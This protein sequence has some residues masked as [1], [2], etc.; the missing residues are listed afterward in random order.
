MTDL[1]AMS[2]PDRQAVPFIDLRSVP[3]SEGAKAFVQTLLEEIIL[4]TWPA[5]MQQRPSTILK[6]RQVLAGLVGDLLRIRI[7][8]GDAIGKHGVADRDF[9]TLPF[10]RDVFLRTRDALIGR[11]LLQ[12]LGGHRWLSHSIAPGTVTGSVQACFQ[13]TAELLVLAE[14]AG[15]LGR[16]LEDWGAHWT[17]PRSE[18]APKDDTSS[19]VILRAEKTLG[20]GNAKST[21]RPLPINLTDPRVDAIAQELREHNAFV[22]EAGVDGVAYAGLARVFNNGDLDGFAWRWGGRMV[23]LPGG[24]YEGERKADRFTVMRLGGERVGEVDLKASYLT[25]LYG[26]RG[27]PLDASV[28]DPYDVEGVDRELVKKWITQALGRG[29]AD[30]KRW[31]DEARRHYSSQFPGRNITV[32]HPITEARDAILGVHP[33]LGDLKC[34]PDV[35]VH[36]LAFHES[37][38]MLAAMRRLRQDGVPSLPVH[39]CLIVPLQ[40]RRFAQ[41]Q[42]AEAFSTHIE[43]ETG[44]PSAAVPATH[45]QPEEDLLSPVGE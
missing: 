9:V 1:D 32:D 41:V 42:L 22:A 17:R 13:L 15:V 5:T 37:E 21:G 44:A 36:S 20:A 30:A 12:F 10:S 31:S 38:I 7:R 29:D 18:T 6:H 8:T 43:V 24:G 26:L 2:W 28:N 35:S 14:E 45:L 19:L 16:D 33:V 27:L 40:Q 34:G 25:I 11:G 4:P 39:D 23:S 3:L